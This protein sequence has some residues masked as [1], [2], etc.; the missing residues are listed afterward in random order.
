MKNEPTQLKQFLDKFNIFHPVH[1]ILFLIILIL[2]IQRFYHL[3]FMEVQPWDESLYAIRA[4]SILN[5]GD[6]IDQT[7]HSIKGLYAAAHPPL[8]IWLTAI[9]MKIFGDNAI[10]VRIWS[11]IFGALTVILLYFMPRDRLTGFFASFTL[12]T[13]AL[14]TVYSRLGQ[15]DITYTF[16][17]ISGLFF[18]QQFEKTEKR[19]WLILTG[20]AFGLAQMSK[21]IVGLFLPLILAAYLFLRIISKRESLKNSIKQ[22]LTVFGTGL[23]IAAPWHIFMLWKYGQEFINHYFLFHIYQRVLFGVEENIPSLGP[24]FFVNQLL[25]ILSI[26]LVMAFTQIRKLNLRDQR[27]QVIYFL[28]FLI[29]FIIFTISI[30]KLWTYALPM[31]PPLALLAGYGFSE[32]WSQKRID[33]LTIGLT[34][35][36]GVWAFSYDLRNYVKHFSASSDLNIQIIVIVLAIVVV[37]ILIRTWIRGKVFVLTALSY[38][39]IMSFIAP[40]EMH[41]T[42]L[43]QIA[44][45][46]RQEECQNLVC[47]D[48]AAFPSPQISYYFD[49]IDLGW[50]DGAQFQFV[51]PENLINLESEP[52]ATTYY[53]INFLHWTDEFLELEIQLYQHAEPLLIDKFYHVYRWQPSHSD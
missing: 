8:Y 50:Q 15:L 42:N 51:R 18:W 11:A 39:L 4:R 30:T 53:I 7:T 14:F 22:W 10:T 6:W 31:L 17:I 34:L 28:A 23:A 35:L 44:V 3:G 52:E 2:A 5:F 33:S 47:L 45:R 1:K 48:T 43:A 36:I 21:I 9:T 49:G 32:I 46:F 16:F 37:F 26:A 27:E 38:L 20:F 25:V 24:F 12:G 40:V 13:T 41:Q 29:P 19:K